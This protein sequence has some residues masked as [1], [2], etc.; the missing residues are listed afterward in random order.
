MDAPEPAPVTRAVFPL[1]EKGTGA[2]GA[3]IAYVRKILT[4]V[5][6]AIL[7]IFIQR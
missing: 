7:G 4:C 5:Y 6:R 1:T 2:V 3:A